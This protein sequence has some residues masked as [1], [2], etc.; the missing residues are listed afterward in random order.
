MSADGNL[1]TVNSY[2][3]AMA[4]SLGIRGYLAEILVQLDVIS[5]NT[6]IYALR[7]KLSGTAPWLSPPPAFLS[8][9]HFTLNKVSSSC[10]RSDMHKKKDLDSWSRRHL[11][12]LRVYTIDSPST[13]EI[14]D[15]LSIQ[16]RG[17]DGEEWVLVH[18]ADPTRWMTP[19]DKFD[20][21]ARE[22]AS[23]VYLP[24][25]VQSMLPINIARDVMSILPQT[26]SSALTFAVRLADDGEIIDYEIYPSLLKDIVRT[27]YTEVDAI[28]DGND[29]FL[30]D[31]ELHRLYELALKRLK[32]REKAGSYLQVIPKV[33]PKVIDGEVKVNFSSLYSKAQ[34]L[35]SEMMVLTGQVAALYALKHNIP[36]PY[37]V[38]KPPQFN[39][40][41]HDFLKTLPP[42]VRE[43]EY[44]SVMQRADESTTP[45]RH[46]GVGLDAYVRVSSPIRRYSDILAHFQIKAHLR[47]QPL[48]FDQKEMEEIIE[49]LKV[50]ENDIYKLQKDSIRF[51]INQYFKQRKNKTYNGLV[52]RKTDRKLVVLLL[53]VGREVRVSIPKYPVKPG[54][55]VLVSLVDWDLFRAKFCI[56]KQKRDRTG[57]A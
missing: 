39:A 36:V 24:D 23:S 31:M 41:Y 29:I 18:I 10:L 44:L 34:I 21:A 40:E 48:P 1:D 45:Q 17:P 30:H 7:H 51:W 33:E 12:S 19:N 4:R 32:W 42:L 38:Q 22:R 49:R 16:Y 46:F 54:D 27:N 50:P 35:V 28:L 25:F 15:G 56:V 37:R 3:Y 52:I 6:D 8:Y 11:E 14:D 9:A 43:T 47:H 53:E 5:K 57:Q 13:I 2:V 20:L 55:V 26:E